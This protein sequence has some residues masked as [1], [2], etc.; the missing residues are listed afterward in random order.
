MDESDKLRRGC[1]SCKNVDATAA[2]RAER[3][4]KVRREF[5]RDAARNDCV[6]QAIKR[7]TGIPGALAKF[8]ERLA[9]G[10]RDILSRD[11][12]TWTAGH[13]VSR[14]LDYRIGLMILSRP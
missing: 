5:D 4:A 10:L 6:A 13:T 7:L 14:G 8:R 9:V 3:S 1:E 11:F 12:A 2:R